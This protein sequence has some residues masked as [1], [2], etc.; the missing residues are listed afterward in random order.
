ME[1][2]GGSHGMVVENIKEIKWHTT[3]AMRWLGDAE[4]KIKG[5]ENK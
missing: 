2:T 1:D 5:E 3:K 4:K